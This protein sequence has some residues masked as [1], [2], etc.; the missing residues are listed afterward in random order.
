MHDAEKSA[1]Q[2]DIVWR[3]HLR[4]LRRAR[5]LD[6]LVASMLLLLL[7]FGWAARF[8]PLEHWAGISFASS[9]SRHPSGN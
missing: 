9:G 4:T 5:R 3:A 1:G 2:E 8:A 7:I 6:S